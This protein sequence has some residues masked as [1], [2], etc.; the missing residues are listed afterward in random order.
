MSFFVLRIILSFFKQ[1]FIK[2]MNSGARFF[3]IIS[4]VVLQPTDKNNNLKQRE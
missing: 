4:H 1:S 2:I 3:F